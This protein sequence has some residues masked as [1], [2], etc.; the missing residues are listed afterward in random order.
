MNLKNAVHPQMTQ[1]HADIS[2]TCL[3]DVRHPEGG[4]GETC[5]PLIAPVFICVYL[6][7]LRISG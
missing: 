5:R 2:K 3:Q 1:I 7:H 6:R 4:S